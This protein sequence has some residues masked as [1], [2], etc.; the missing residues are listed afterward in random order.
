MKTLQCTSCEVTIVV[1]LF[2]G[3]GVCDDVIIVSAGALVETANAKAMI[4]IR[5]M[6]ILP[7]C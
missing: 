4:F 1:P 6:A 2:A 3:G 7:I 5:V